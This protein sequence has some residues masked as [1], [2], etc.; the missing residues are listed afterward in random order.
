MKL[1]PSIVDRLIC[2]VCGSKLVGQETEVRCT[3][4]SCSAVFPIVDDIPILIN[5]EKSVFSLEDFRRRRPTFFR[6][7]ENWL[8][9]SFAKYL[10]SLDHNVTTRKNF[11]AFVDLLF[12]TSTKP[13]V[14]VVGGSIAGMGMEAFLERN[15]INRVETD[16]AFGPRTALICDAHDLPFETATFDGVVAQAVLEHVVDPYRC[17]EE[18]HR[19]LKPGGLVY[20]EI[21]FMQ[22]VHG[23]EYD[24]TR[25]T[26]LGQRRLFRRFD[27]VKSGVVD[28]PGTALG[29]SYRYFLLSFSGSPF[30]RST[31]SLFARLTGFW[32]KYFDYVLQ[33]KPGSLDA[34]S[35]LFFLGKKSDRV[36]SDSEL[37][38]RYRGGFR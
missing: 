20:A 1:N 16:A 28:G 19:V 31:L 4:S 10:P 25:F 7:D 27:E 33:H 34:S 24:F 26:H 36:V 15:D 13:N 23:G 30:W 2:P 21:P 8:R 3:S 12:K 37:V 5:E 6:R 22:Q 32:L 14:L 11:G 17:V 18:I 35:G 29:W 38:K 9:R